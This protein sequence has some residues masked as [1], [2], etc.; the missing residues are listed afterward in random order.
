MRRCGRP[1]RAIAFCAGSKSRKAARHAGCAG[2]GATPATARPARCVAS[3]TPPAWP[4]CGCNPSS[5]PF[6]PRPTAWS[7]WGRMG[8]SSGSTKWLRRIS[9]S[10]RSAICFSTS[11]TWCVTRRSPRTLRQAPFSATCAFAA[12][13]IH[14]PVRSSCRCRFIPT[15]TTTSCCCRRTSPRCRRPKPCAATSWPTCRTRSERR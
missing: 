9:A 10:C 7:C 5:R 13:R 14:R 15:P 3:K 2:S 11:A 8:E 4:T 1:C 12:A 6:R